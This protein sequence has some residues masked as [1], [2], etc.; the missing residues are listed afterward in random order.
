MTIIVWRSPGFGIL[1][2]FDLEPVFWLLDCPRGDARRKSNLQFN[3]QNVVDKFGNN[4][5]RDPSRTEPGLNLAIRDIFGLDRL[6]SLNVSL[7]LGVHLSRGLG[8]IQLFAD[9]AAQIFVRHFP[10]LAF[11]VLVDEPRKLEFGL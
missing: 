10:F 3:F 1:R 9:I 2:S 6:Q 4:D 7:I 11:R 8:N 5:R